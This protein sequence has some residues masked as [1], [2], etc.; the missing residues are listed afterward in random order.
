VYVWQ[1]GLN[2]NLYSLQVNTIFT[3]LDSLGLWIERDKHRDNNS[4]HP[5]HLQTC[6]WVP[7]NTS[8]ET[9]KIGFKSVSSFLHTHTVVCS[10][11]GHHPVGSPQVVSPI[12]PTQTKKQY[13]VCSFGWNHTNG[14]VHLVRWYAEL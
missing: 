9:T 11:T 10:C 4:L 5:H 7:V 12:P 8:E 2:A 13:S 14:Q 1:C 6:G 3:C